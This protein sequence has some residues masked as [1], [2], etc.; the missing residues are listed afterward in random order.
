MHVTEEERGSRWW[1]IDDGGR[2]FL[3]VRKGVVLDAYEWVGCRDWEEARQPDNV[4][5]VRAIVDEVKPAHTIYYLKLTP[6]VSEYRVQPMQVG[7]HSSIDV[8]TII[9]E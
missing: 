8:D 3:L 5:R 2:R 6:I 1:T 4:G 7:V 9:G